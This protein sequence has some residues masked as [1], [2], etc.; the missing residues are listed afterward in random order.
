M[1][2]LSLVYIHS[3]TSKG[4]LSHRATS[5][6]HT[7]QRRMHSCYAGC[8]GPKEGG[9]ERRVD[10]RTGGKERERNQEA[11]RE[12]EGEEGGDA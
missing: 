6:Y 3:L 1:I 5:R 4:C 2:N 10:T 12:R 8:M 11:R 7:V 9:D